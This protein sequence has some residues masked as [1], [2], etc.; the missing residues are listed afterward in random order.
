VAVA[1]TSGVI[2]TPHAGRSGWSSSHDDISTT[3]K[4]TTMNLLRVALRVDAA[5]CGVMGLATV[6]G[7]AA[8]DSVL[9]IP[10]GWL[11]GLGLVLIACAVGLGLLAVSRA[12]PGGL[13]WFVVVGNLG[14]VAASV[15]AV[16]F[17]VWPLTAV[18]TAVVIAQAVAVLALAD[19]EW[20][21]AHRAARVA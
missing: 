7:A 4:E 12:A 10:A 14:W 5:A 18:G 11:V 6:F 13:V 20:L 15:A 17:D 8:L 3:T 19:L 9:G 21:A 2:D 16:T 1:I